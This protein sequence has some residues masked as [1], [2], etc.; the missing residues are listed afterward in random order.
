MANIYRVFDMVEY[1]DYIELEKVIKTGKL[2]L[3]RHNKKKEYL[4]NNAIKYRSKECFDLLLESK[5]FDPNNTW[6]NG[7]DKAIYYYKKAT[8]PSN[9]Y[10][11]DAYKNKNINI[12]NSIEELITI[13]EY[14]DKILQTIN[15]KPEF[16][17]NIILSSLY[18]IAIFK[19]YFNIGISLNLITDEVINSIIENLRYGDDHLINDI[20]T[21]LINNNFTN[22]LCDYELI[23]EFIF[24]NFENEE[25]LKLFIKNLQVNHDEF[26]EFL[27]DFF[28][29]HNYTIF[30]LEYFYKNY[31]ILK[32]K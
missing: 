10:Y 2:D 32:L 15:E 24:N 27:I 28:S 31:N 13:D 25:V 7:F 4:I 11:V 19:K 14:N 21:E 16:Y 20:L 23:K 26:S 6:T 3:S 8:N 5:Y 12:E 9:Y 22:F 1:N 18:N 30:S 17:V 29:E